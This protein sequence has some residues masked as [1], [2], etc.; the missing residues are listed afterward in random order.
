MKRKS[1][2]R[3]VGLTSAIICCSLVGRFLSGFDRKYSSLPQPQT[4]TACSRRRRL[5]TAC[6]GSSRRFMAT[7]FAIEDAESPRRRCNVDLSFTRVSSDNQTARPVRRPFLLHIRRP[8]S[9]ADR[10]KTVA[11]ICVEVDWR[12]RTRIDFS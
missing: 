4:S 5:P 9:S 7:H 2:D 10:R 3:R 11:R 6:V 12:V 1:P 8:P